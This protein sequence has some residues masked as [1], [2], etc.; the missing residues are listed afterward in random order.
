M[1]KIL[2]AE[3]NEMNRRLLRDVLAYYG[4]EIIEAENGQVAVEKAKQQPPDLIFLDIQ[5]PVMNGYDA[6]KI[7][8]EM[9][10]TKHIK[11]IAMTSFAMAGDR[12]KIMAAGFDEYISKPIDTRKLPET[13]K[14]WLEGQAASGK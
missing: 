14:K 6:I 10:E 11:V 2:I 9:P 8:K 13:V 4:Y 7:L 3:D 5:M 1:K 12:E